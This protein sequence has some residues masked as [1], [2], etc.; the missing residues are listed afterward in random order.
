LSRH[1][2][3][4]EEDKGLFEAILAPMIRAPKDVPPTAVAVVQDSDDDEAQEIE[5]PHI[6]KKSRFSK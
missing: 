2:I 1:I 6:V 5:V 3:A 4:L